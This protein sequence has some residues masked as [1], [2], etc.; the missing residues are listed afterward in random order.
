MKAGRTSFEAA[1]AVAAPA[2]V[3]AL[4]RHTA[5]IDFLLPAY[6]ELHGELES[7]RGQVLGELAR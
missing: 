6:I 2:F 3:E 5:Y 7:L 4:N 1:Q